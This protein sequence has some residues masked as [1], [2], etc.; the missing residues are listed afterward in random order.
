MLR[1]IKTLDFSQEHVNILES[2][3]RISAKKIQLFRIASTIF[4]FLYCILFIATAD[5]PPKIAASFF[6]RLK[7]THPNKSLLHPMGIDHD[8]NILPRSI[9]PHQKQHGFQHKRPLPF[10]RLGLR[11]V[12]HCIL[13]DRV[14][15]AS[16]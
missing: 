12:H 4:F 1:C 14:I 5:N 15:R 2:R 3:K 8:H 6:S 16:D 7:K 13:L 11:T 10:N 9:D